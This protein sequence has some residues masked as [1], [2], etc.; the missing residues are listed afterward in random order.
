MVVFGRRKIKSCSSDEVQ[1]AK[2]PFEKR[3]GSAKELARSLRYAFT[4]ETQT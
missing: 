1:V 2:F 3:K 4:C